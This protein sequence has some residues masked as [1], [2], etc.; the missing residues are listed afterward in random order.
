[1]VAIA[2]IAVLAMIAA[3][4]FTRLIDSSSVEKAAT[5]LS[6]DLR[7]ARSTAIKLG[8][9]V[10]IC[11]SSSSFDD[12]PTCQG[13]GAANWAS[14]WIIFMDLDSDGTFDADETLLKRQE[15]LERVSAI[16]ENAGGGNAQ[17]SFRFN[18]AGRSPGS[19]DSLVVPSRASESSLQRII[20]M[21]STGRNR[22]TAA[23]ATSC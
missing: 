14:G 17:A 15:A 18:A 5:A 4:S 16:D 8:R 2:I 19:Q 20:C 7:N 22:T 13:A 12:A 11:A 9:S 23:G 1:M 10:S 3:P 6:D 21:A